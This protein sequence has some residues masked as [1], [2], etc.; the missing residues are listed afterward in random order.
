MPICPPDTLAVVQPHG[1]VACFNIFPVFYF[2]FS[3]IFFWFSNSAFTTRVSGPNQE[4]VDLPLVT[5]SQC[6]A[7]QIFMLMDYALPPGESLQ[8]SLVTDASLSTIT[9]YNVLADSRTGNPNRTVILGSHSDSVPAGPG[10]N[11]NGSG[12]ALNLEILAQVSRIQ[13]LA[14]AF[15][16]QCNSFSSLSLCLSLAPL[17]L[18]SWHLG[19]S[20]SCRLM[21]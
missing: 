10:I 9:A 17:S 15:F 1:S 7:D 6:V 12:T 18:R 13:F 20:F 5:M 8:G 21:T 2:P 4:L 14:R 11:D 16:Y 19:L 3:L